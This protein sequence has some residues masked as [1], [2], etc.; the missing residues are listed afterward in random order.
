MRNTQHNELWRTVKFALFS[1]SAGII[2]LGSFAL[3]NELLH[4]HYWFS[5]L[6]A[7][8][9]SIVWNFTLNRRYT[10]KASGSVPAAMLKVFAFY[11]VFT[12]ASTVLGNWLVETLLWN[13][14]LV[15][16]LNMACNLVTE[17]LFDKHVVY[18]NTIDTNALAKREEARTE[19]SGV[20]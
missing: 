14:Y 10:F 11:C 2:E 15:T 13:A 12:P 1:C 20:R 3:L 5:Y 4:L 9:L 17:Y 19:E 7:L 6:T 16:G 18:R 8:I